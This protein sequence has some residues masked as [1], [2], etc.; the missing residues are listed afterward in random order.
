MITESASRILK[1][2]TVR[3][4]MQRAGMMQFVIFKIRRIKLG[5]GDYPELYSDR[6]IELGELQRVANKT[7]LPAS[8]Q[9]GKAFPSGKGAADFIGVG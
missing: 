8:A 3:V 1:A 7:G 5:S 9:N 4:R 6:V 2:G